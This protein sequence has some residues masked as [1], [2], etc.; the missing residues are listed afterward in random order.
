[1]RGIQWILAVVIFI[2][3][4]SCA[5]TGEMGGGSANVRTYDTDYETVKNKVQ[6][7]IRESN[8]I[9]REA[10]E[11]EDQ[12]RTN[13][14]INKSGRVGYEQVQQHAG[15]VI[16]EEIAEG[17]TRVEVENP[18]YHFTVPS[19][20]KEDYARI[21]FRRLEELVEPQT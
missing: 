8:I 1:M 20:H 15:R 7:V 10:S 3:I 9:L 6:E 12:K 17:Q 21:I 16:V 11:L 19:H 4:Y 18:E 5:G 14:L 2:L 13:F